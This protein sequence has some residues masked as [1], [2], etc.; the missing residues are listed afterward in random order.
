M[1]RRWIVGLGLLLALNL[2]AVGRWHFDDGLYE[3]FE[4]HDTRTILKRLQQPHS[5]WEWF[6]GDWVLGNGFYRPLPSVLYQLDY[7]LWGDHLLRWKL[8]NGVLAVLNALLV[9]ALGYVLAQ[10]RDFALTVGLIFTLWQTGFLPPLPPWLSWVALAG[11]IV[12]G[13]YTGN[14]RRGAL[15]GAFALAA[16]VELRFIPNLADLHQQSFAYRAVGWIPGRTATL[17][18]AFV[19]VALIGT[20]LLARTGKARWGALG[21]LGCI[22]ALLSYEQAIVVPV[23]MA[24]VGWVCRSGDAVSE[25]PGRLRLP[26]RALAL[27]G[28]CLLLLVPYALFYRTH[29]PSGTDYHQQ[30]F[31]RLRTLPIAALNWLVPPAPEVVLQIGLVRTAPLT[32][33]F[34]SFWAAQLAA[35]A[36][37]AALREGLRR[38]EALLGWLGSVIAYAPLMPVLPLMHYYYLPAALR[39]LW[40]GIL[41]LCL[42]TPRP[43][44]G[45]ILVGMGDASCPK[46]SSLRL[47]N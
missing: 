1:V 17:M 24:L 25:A 47:R 26:W 3:S 6:V 36:Y 9:V 31:K 12:W 40:I 10:R 30:R 15:V 4:N 27:S 16:L 20:G 37:L 22:G 5:V 38:R 7:W 8:T 28:L 21:L 44:Q 34:P 19:L 43:T 14:W 35:I 29:I 18:T 45:V 41:L 39:A 46:P 11:G 2:V 33:A 32:L 23:L 42:L 13:W